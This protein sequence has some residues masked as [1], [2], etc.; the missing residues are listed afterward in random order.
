MTGK[1]VDT[2][3]AVVAN[4]RD[5]NASDECRHQSITVLEALVKR[6]CIVIDTEGSILAE[7]GA[8]LHPEGQPGVGDL[9]YRHVLDNQGNPRRVRIVRTVGARGDALR[10]AFERGTLADFDP[11]DRK[12]A[13]C[14][15]VARVP[16]ATAT[17][18]DW[19]EHE[20]GLAA[21]G[22]Q[23]EYVCGREA[24]GRFARMHVRARG[25]RQP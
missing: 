19:V 10:G 22:V 1:V 9:F 12:F 3:V 6:G 7:Y 24:A 16:V 14:A 25:R 18:S 11:S 21:C 23:I 15:V 8:R 13:L 20:V 4:G 17:D 2:N 5:V